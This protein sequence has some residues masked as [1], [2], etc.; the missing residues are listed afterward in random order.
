MRRDDMIKPINFT[1]NNNVYD[2]VISINSNL[3]LIL[4]WRKG[5]WEDSSLV[6]NA[7][8]SSRVPEFGLQL[9]SGASYN[10]S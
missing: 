5:A 2:N 8:C 4:K 7:Y 6:K 1:I 3:K 9:P 10:F